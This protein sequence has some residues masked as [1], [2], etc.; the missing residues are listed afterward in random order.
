MTDFHSHVLPGIDDGSASVAES[1]AMLQLEAA[2]GITHVV[3]TPHFYPR[4]ET[5]D[6]FLE[7]RDA[8]EALLRQEMAKYPG[9]PGLSVGAEVY[10]FRGISESEYLP[11]LTIRE[12]SCILIEM[13]RSPWTDG[14]YAELEAIWD[15][16]G[17]RPVIAHIDRYIAPFRTQR[18]PER[19]EELPVLVQANASFFLDRAT[20]RMAMRLLRQD[21]IQLLGSDCHNLTGRAPNLGAAV[22]QIE[23]R[24]GGAVLEQIRSYQNE[25]LAD[26]PS[27]R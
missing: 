5:P 13:P 7:K 22:R 26:E 20:S 9:L 21:R 24:L 2:Q 16:W 25:I 27:N 17:I 4:Y 6:A 18:I 3:A 12:K 1:I 23:K 15:R 8:A 10:F 14:M 11:R 19:L